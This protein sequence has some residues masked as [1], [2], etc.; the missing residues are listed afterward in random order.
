MHKSQGFTLWELII[1]ILIVSILA[2]IGTSSF[3][4]VTTSNRISSEINGL[5]GDMQFARSQAAKTGSYV[6]VCPAA[7]A[8]L[9]SCA[10]TSTWTKGWI[11][12][13]D[14]NGNGVINNATDRVIRTQASIAPDTLVSSVGTFKF[15]TFNREGYGSNGQTAWATINLNSSPANAQW[16]RCLAVSAVGAIVIEKSG[17]STPTTC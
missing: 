13:L 10:N 6:S 15:V 2:S 1:V 9:N 16:R 12:F 4:Y 11:V 5:L 17:A 7:N 14:L 8:S 3:K